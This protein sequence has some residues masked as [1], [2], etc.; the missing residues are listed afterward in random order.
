MNESTA[1]AVPQRDARTIEVTVESI[2]R[3]SEGV[4]ALTLSG[5]NPLPEWSPGAHIDVHLPEG[6]V[7]QYSLCGDTR[8]R[9][10]YR[11]AVL[12]EESGRG[13]SRWIHDVLRPGAKLAISPPRNNFAMV[14]SSSVLFIA[15]GIGITPILPMVMA[16]ETSGVDWH[17]L[18]GGRTRESMAF[19]DELPGEGKR[20]ILHPQNEAGHL[21]LNEWLAEP[22]PETHIY[23]CGPEPLIAAVEAASAAWP[24]E[25]VHFERFRAPEGADEEVAGPF[26]VV[27]GRSGEILTVPAE[28]S[29]LDVLEDQGLIVLSSC[30][31]GTCGTCETKV[32]DGIPDHRDWVLSEAEKKAND[33]MMVCVSRACSAR[34]TLDL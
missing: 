16:A 13:G 19:I 2:L 7:R 33:T 12:R 3:A 9:S 32:L 22:Q 23:T 11:V 1:L 10:R 17:L 20:V 27:L 8:D 28:K 29:I 21:P 15:G 25:N 30:R 5:E 24:S 6:M 4:V 18:Y 14:A 26:E 34:I 31:E